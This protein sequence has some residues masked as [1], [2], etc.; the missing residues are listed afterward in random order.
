[1]DQTK[2]P[3]G[4]L[5]TS[6]AGTVQSCEPTDNAAKGHF[7][8]DENDVHHPDLAELPPELRSKTAGAVSAATREKAPVSL[9]DC[10]LFTNP[11]I[12][13]PSLACLNSLQLTGQHPPQSLLEISNPLSTQ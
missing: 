12:R 8:V 3:P 13:I 9:Q 10:R 5:P 1:M 7:L 11:T 4:S 2:T 6:W